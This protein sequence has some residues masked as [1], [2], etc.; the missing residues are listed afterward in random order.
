[1]FLY[2]MAG[3]PFFFRSVPAFF[4]SFLTGTVTGTMFVAIIFYTYTGIIGRHYLVLDIATFF[5]SVVI[6]FSVSYRLA[7]QNLRLLPVPLLVAFNVGL[8]VGFFIFTYAPPKIALFQVYA[9]K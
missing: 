1:M 3:W 7:V 6:A 9:G 2:V 4:R 8:M 5:L